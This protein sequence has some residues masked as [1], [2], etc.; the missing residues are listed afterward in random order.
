MDQALKA[1]ADGLWASA[2]GQ[3]RAFVEGLTDAIANR[4]EPSIE[5]MRPS[6]WSRLEWLANGLNPPFLLA[7]L[8]EWQT[9]SSGPFIG[10]IPGVWSRLRLHLVILLARLLL[11]RLHVRTS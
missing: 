3:L 7:D 2:N 5:T 1:H 8:N 6:A 4:L 11:R 10:F 9:D